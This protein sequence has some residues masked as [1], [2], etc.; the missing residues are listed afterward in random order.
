MNSSTNFPIPKRI[1][2]GQSLTEFA[3]ILVILLVVLAGIVDLGRVFYAYIIIRDAAQE[4]AVYGSIAPKDNI[5]T[6]KN[7]VE[8]RVETAF[9]DPA[10]PSNVPINISKMNVQTDI[11]GSAC[12]A[13]G[14]GVRVRIDYTLPVTM[15]F[16]GTIIGSQ[17]MNMSAS[18]ENAILSPVCP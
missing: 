15:P 4:G 12:A 2:H 5:T 14:N 7:E 3:L 11:I 1:E 9:T 8:A 13:P 10:D 17:D 16:L 18:V 6:F